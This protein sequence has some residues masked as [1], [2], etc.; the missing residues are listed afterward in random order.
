MVGTFDRTLHDMDIPQG[1]LRGAR[2]GLRGG[3]SGRNGG[4]KCVIT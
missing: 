2:M 3:F 4:D 1:F